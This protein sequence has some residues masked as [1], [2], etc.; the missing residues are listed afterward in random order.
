MII[1]KNLFSKNIIFFF[2]I[3]LIFP[4]IKS[5]NYF[6][7]Y[8]LLS[9]DFYLLINN[10][11]IIKIDSN[12]HQQ[13]ILFSYNDANIFT[14][15]DD[16]KY[17]S[18]AESPSGSYLIC[19]IKQYIYVILYSE[20]RL[21]NTIIQDEI[22]ERLIS[23]LTY[24]EEYLIVCFINSNKELQIEK[25]SYS[26][27]QQNLINKVTKKIEYE[28]SSSEYS[29]NYGVSCEMM[30]DS[31][32]QNDLLICFIESESLLLTG[33]VFDPETDFSFMYLVISMKK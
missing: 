6:R 20:S 30:K 4:F 31:N 11:G 2:T 13:I 19:R 3:Y 17:I 24:Q 29:N 10:E 32:Y 28:D 15:K 22:N 8:N 21:C 16:I 25:Y 27:P 18:F 5:F 9:G 33:L 7:A 12:T 23:I 26:N 14:S 1:K